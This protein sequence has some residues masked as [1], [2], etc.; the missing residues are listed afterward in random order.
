MKRF[1]NL[2]AYIGVSLLIL[3]MPSCKN[4][5]EINPEITL[6]KDSINFTLSAGNNTLA[7]KSNL[8][9]TAT[10]S[11][12]WCTVTPSSGEAGTHQLVVAVTANTFGLREAVITIKAGSLSKEVKIKQAFEK[13]NL[14]KK[15]ISIDAAGSDVV[16]NIESSSSYTV[17]LP[18]WIT[19]K[20]TSADKTVQTFTAAANPS[21]SARQGSIVYVS[22]LLKDSVVVLQA[23]APFNIPDDAIGMSSTAMQLAARIKVGLNIGNTMEAT[24]GETAWGNPLITNDLIKTIKQ[25]GFNAIRLPC[26]WNCYADQ[27]TAKIS[28]SWLNRVKQVVKYCVDNDMYVIVNIHWDGGWLENNCTEDKKTA[29]NAKQKAFW[30]QIAVALRGFDEHVLFASANEPNVKDATQ[31]AVLLSYHQ[32]FVDAVRSTGGKNAYR[33]LVVQGP[34]TDITLTNTLM[35]QLPTDKVPNK[36]MAEV[37]YYTPWNFCGM[38]K[39]ETWGNQ[40][41]YWGVPNHSTTDTAHNPTWG[42][43]ATVDANFALMKKQFVDKGI[44]V[45]IGEFGA[46]TRSNLT[47]DAL[48]LHLASRAYYFKYVVKKSIANGLLPFFW[49]TGGLI[50]RNNYTVSD[51]QSLDGLIQGA[52]GL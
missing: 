44:P 23:G 52:A 30:E 11:Q 41:Y 29:N 6:A 31:M 42:E 38:T 50:N 17:T 3:S 4:D 46:I 40:F 26:D 51:Q 9:W 34:S 24:G 8:S 16:V 18:M 28:D 2:L 7:I 35:T 48:K 39:D 32:T 12:S 20:S 43:E 19:T 25:N 27:S 13:L 1:K 14:D 5:P 15:S 47:G 36:M 22:G 37:H 10:S 21:A 33:V 49:D 45:V